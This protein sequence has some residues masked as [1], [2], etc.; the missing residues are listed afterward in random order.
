MSPQ[1][2]SA[3]EDIELGT[4]PAV[5]WDGSRM[6]LLD[7]RRLPGEVV[8]ASFDAACTVAQAIA[9]MVVRGAP[10]IG[11]AA[12]Y[13]AAM[14]VSGH[15]ERLT[16]HGAWR[17]AVDRDFALLAAARPTAVNLTWALDRMR[18]CLDSFA[19]DPLRSSRPSVWVD[20]V[21][22]E[23]EQIHAEDV[24]ANRAMGKIGAALIRERCNV[25][26][27]C[28]AGALATGGYGTALGVVRSAFRDGRISEV[29]ANETRPWLQGARLTAWELGRDGIPVRLMADGAA[30][31]AMQQ[32][33]VEWVIVGADRIARNGDVANKIGTYNLAV[34]ARHHGIKFMVVAPTS[35]IDLA[36]S[37][38]DSIPIEIRPASEVLE[39][40]NQRI[41]AAGAGAWNPVF[42][43]TPASLV[44]VLVTET[45]AIRCPDKETI[46]THV[47]A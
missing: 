22:R 7:Q 27:H 8:Y 9:D 46:D 26:T 17:E 41:A 32:G 47:R 18:R 40:G 39:L 3:N 13:G 11:I 29:F 43:I 12:A 16:I 10:A 37:D 44:D 2:L 38:G 21:R 23:A 4:P 20:L 24:A 15:I 45:G 5:Q 33:K 30:S 19:T 36:V 1:V 35:T 34:S 14:S 31:Y 28:N 42:D 25:L 6:R